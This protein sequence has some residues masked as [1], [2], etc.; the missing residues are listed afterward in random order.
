MEDGTQILLVEDNPG[1]VELVREALSELSSWRCVLDSVDRLATA[2]A[3]LAPESRHGVD[4]VLLDL[5]LPDSAGIATLV[6][7]QRAAPHVPVVVLTGSDDDT[8]ALEALRKG[9]QDYLVKGKCDG[10][11]IRRSIH[12]A[13]ERRRAEA[14][15]LQLAAER[16]ARAAAEDAHARTALLA[17]AS[18]LLASTFGYQDVMTSV[19]ALAVPRYADCCVVEIL[20]EQET[21]EHLTVAHVRATDADPIEKRW[22]RYARD[23]EAPSCVATAV[24]ARNPLLV[25]DVSGDDAIL[26]KLCPASAIVV[27]MEIRGTLIGILALVS[28]RLA[29]RYDQ[30]DLNTADDLAHRIALAV[31]NSR[32][33]DQARKAVR[34][35]NDALR[36]RDEFMAMASHEL[37]TPL[38]TLVLR[39]QALHRLLHELQTGGPE[40]LSQKLEKAIRQTD[41]L[42]KLVDMLLDVS[43]VTSDRLELD[44]ESLDLSEL[45]R[46]VALR[47]AG[48]D[49]RRAS[50]LQVHA[51]TGVTGEWDRSRID[52]VLTNLLSNAMKFGAG[53]PIDVDLD[54]DAENVRI[55][56][57]DRGIGIANED[58]RRIFGRFERA[59]PVREY[60]G[61]GLGLYIARLIVEAHQG[62]IRVA[63][64]P[65]AGSTFT[66]EIPRHPP[67]SSNQVRA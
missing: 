11:L 16:A 63:S 27:P 17:E 14:A 44:L 58:V 52:Q 55:T 60:G 64:T 12:Y 4:V 8:R 24:R 50:M 56:V 33:Y 41:R 20:N 26:G 42:T 28:T 67:R 9:A 45:V 40:E 61:L 66:V 47:C 13:I 43:R 18:S 53:Q 21:T 1:D 3:R 30:V 48:T 5:N 32:L 35:A 46:D 25:P 54:A 62:K 59:V 51:P 6:E 34:K 57:R 22:R 19:A 23:R 7:L 31:D 49:H 10:E 15:N 39:L 2:I 65:G 29:H 36:A 38:T 37:R